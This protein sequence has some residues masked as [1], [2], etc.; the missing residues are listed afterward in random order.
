[1]RGIF[2]LKEEAEV[3]SMEPVRKLVCMACTLENSKVTGFKIPCISFKKVPEINQPRCFINIKSLLLRHL[4]EYTH[5]IRA[6]KHLQERQIK[7]SKVEEVHNALQHLL[8]FCLNSSLSFEECPKLLATVHIGNIN[9]STW[10]I[11]Q[12]CDMVGA[13]LFERTVHWLKQQK[14]ITVTLDIGTCTGI[15]LLAVLF[16]SDDTHE[17]RLANI[18]PV[19]SKKGTDL[20]QTCF[21]ILK[22]E[23]KIDNEKD[24][25]RIVSGF[26]GD[27]QFIKGNKNFKEKLKELLKN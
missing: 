25:S 18:V 9:Q 15:T 3:D 4:K 13:E 5:I 12:Y 10:F 23:G 19:V 16:I 21:D 22:M 26:T 6:V 2:E 14:S 20:A 1:M 27:G 24:L 8:Y 7:I 11:K 17:V